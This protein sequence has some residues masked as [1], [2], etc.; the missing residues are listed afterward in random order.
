[1]KFLNEIKI[2]TYFHTIFVNVTNPQSLKFA[3]KTFRNVVASEN[4]F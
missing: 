4:N 2:L 1:M 3:I